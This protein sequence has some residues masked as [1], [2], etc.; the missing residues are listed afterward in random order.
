MYP[1]VERDRKAGFDNTRNDFVCWILLFRNFES[2]REV[3]EVFLS[4]TLR[5]NITTRMK[6]CFLLSLV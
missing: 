2:I 6:K 1:F 3:S 5:K 4:I